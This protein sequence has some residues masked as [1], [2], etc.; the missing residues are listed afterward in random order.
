MNANPKGA[1]AARLRKTKFDRLRGIKLPPEGLPGSLTL[2]LTRCG[3]PTCRCAQGE[4]HP[5]WVLTFTR[6][7]R[8]RVERVPKEWVEDVRHRVEEGRAFKEAVAEI[9]AANAELLVLARRQRR[10]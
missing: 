4:G 10:R 8:R 2:N 3:K 5:S 7:G 6:G 9:F 1:D